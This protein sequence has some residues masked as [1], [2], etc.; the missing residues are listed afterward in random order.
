M[1]FI[2]EIWEGLS[3]TTISD[4]MGGER[5]MEMSMKPLNT[6][7]IVIGPACTVHLINNDCSGVFDGLAIAR[8]GDVLV[9]DTGRCTEYAFLGEIVAGMA[10]TIGLAGILVDGLVR[11]SISIKN[12]GFPVF[13]KGVIPRISKPLN[14]SE[15]QTTIQCGGITVHPGDL[16]FGDAD[17]IAVVPPDQMGEVFI[18][19]KKKEE[20]DQEKLARLIDNP[21]A[22]QCFL[23]KKE[24]KVTLD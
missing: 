22:I 1:E 12:S 8:P 4:A 7:S 9:I 19:A 10:R 2:K 18:K 20:M 15:T 16:I 6:A 13:C 21:E 17:G 23:Q 5:I 14:C 3:T 11:D 24:H